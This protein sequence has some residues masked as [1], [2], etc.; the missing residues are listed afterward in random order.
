MPISFEGCGFGYHR[1]SR[2]FTDLELSLPEGRTA[3]LGPNGSGKSTLLCLA[4]SLLHPRTGRVRYRGLDPARRR[5][6]ARYRALVGWMPQ[7]IRPLPGL[8]VREQVGYAG[9]LKGMPRR[10]AWRRSLAALETVELASLADRRCSELSGGQLRR[11]G[12]A[13]TLVHE[14][15]VILLD[16]PTAGLDPA[17]RERFHE[18]MAQVGERSHLIVSTHDVQDLADAY[19]SVVVLDEG[20]VG[21]AGP[22]AGLMAHGGDTPAESIEHAYRRLVAQEV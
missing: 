15:E 21:Y 10:T 20:R 9:W 19:G 6:R 11:V 16:E 14:A 2:V 22:V 12:L 13:Q 8:T 7:G 4:A 1:G 18:I 3:L 17:Q 5:D